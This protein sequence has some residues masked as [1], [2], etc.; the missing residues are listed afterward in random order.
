[1]KSWT[2]AVA[3]LALTACGD[4]PPPLFELQSPRQTGIAF[5]N[6]IVEDDS[7][8]NPQNFD[9]VYNGGGVAVG[10]VNGD[11]RPDL[12]FT[13]NMVSS[14]LY[15]NTGELTFDD[16]TTTAG[17]GTD[18]W[19]T[20]VSMVDID[21]NGLLDIYVSVAGM[22]EDAR[23]NLLF[24][25]QGVGSDGVPRF[26]EEAKARGLADTGYSTL[27]AFFDY[28]RDGDLDLYLL[29]N[30]QEDFGRN[31]LRARL[32][33]GESAS[34]DRLYRN[35][36]DG[37]FTDVSAEAGITI[38][39]YGLGVT[40]SDLDQD[41]W[42]DVYVANDFLSNDLI[43][44]NNGDGTFTNRAATWLEHQAHNGMGMDVADYNNDARPDI[45]VLDMLP[46]G[47]ERQK[48][49]VGE[50][51]YDP[52]MMSLAMGY[53]PQYIRNMLQLNLGPGPDGELHFSE[54]GQLAGI[55]ATDWSWAPLLA[56]LDNDGL[57]DLFITNGYRRDVTN[58]D[59][60]AY[61][62]KSVRTMREAPGERR[63]RLFN[64]LKQ[65]PPVELRDYLF[66]N[67]GDL[68]FTDRSREWGMRDA[69]FANGA[70]YADLD[71]DGDLDLVVNNLDGVADVYRNR[72]DELA[73]RHYLRVVL[74]G[75]DGN[76]NGLGT[77]V[78]ARHQ[79]RTQYL[80]Q[81]PYRGY[82]STVDGVLHFGLGS[83]TVVDSLEIHWP[84]GRYQ[85]L[86]DVRADQR[87]TVDHRDAGPPPE[88]A[89]AALEPLLTAAPA[90][91]GL[92]Y[93]HTE[94]HAPEFRVTPLLPRKHSRDGPGLAI[95]DADGN[96][97]DDV[98]VGADRN[99]AGRI[100]FQ[101][102]PG[103]F[104]ETALPDGS[105]Y[106]DTGALFFDADGDGH[107]DLYVVSGGSFPPMKDA[108]YQDR[109]YVNDGR[110]GLSHAPDALPV[111]DAS[112]S[113]VVAA[114]YDGDG[115]LDLFVGGRI[116]PAE[117]PLPA[118]SFLLRN[119]SRPGSPKFTDVTQDVAPGLARTG[120]VTSALWTDFDLDG[121]VDL[122]VAG[123]WMPLTF[124]R[125]DGDAFTD[126]T[127]TTG[128]AESHGWWNSLAAGD[129]DGDGDTDYV[130]G[131]LGLNSR[132]RASP[133]EPVRV[134]AR[135][136]DGNG[137]I[138]PVLSY[139][140]QGESYPVAPR[141]LM[142]DQIRAMEARFPDYAGYAEA[143]L[144]RTFRR[145]EVADAY[146]AKSQVMESAWV[147]NLGNGE[148]AL[149]P[150]PVRAQFAP[151]FGMVVGDRNDDGALDILMVGNSYATETLFGWYDASVGLLLLGDGEGGFAEV[152]HAASG[153]FVDGDAKA[154]G[155]LRVD[156]D[157]SLILVTQND[158]SLAIFESRHRERRLVPVEP[159][160]AYAMITLADSTIRRQEFYYGSTFQS[161]SSRFLAVPPDAIRAAIFDFS[162][163][164][165]TLH[166]PPRHR[167]PEEAAPC[168]P[169]ASC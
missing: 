34:T 86:R 23:A 40:V 73:D 78:I 91:N 139:Y 143:T 33:K 93:A 90:D 76:R 8:V 74:R 42:P 151:V 169:H 68:T 24:V 138:D 157:R 22:D 30:G 4:A 69:G 95:G 120:L 155:E 39:G 132:F 168:E 85:L 71:A 153:F 126:V 167:R 31:M 159:L 107:L 20:G 25:N 82:K 101:H 131:N 152:D 105:A 144:E 29:T 18:V 163:S 83:A 109:L 92:R 55:H 2:P 1:M 50:S 129:F 104:E 158:D 36:G 77:R 112:G 54:I 37:T 57:K 12:Y 149:R 61:S 156:D 130:A 26:T 56:D 121:R 3:L 98:F 137:T 45:I 75:P 32:K 70:A 62:E 117:Y 48:M 125:N 11:G 140:L 47:N 160:D 6:E 154:A 128:L 59:Y 99:R 13:G 94:Q 14:R 5:A 118:Q 150:L 52:F 72:T 87:I 9:Y 113:S 49:M 161:Q 123:E 43:W 116:I 27:A 134:H 122:L 135:D 142:I 17:V 15:L 162:G 110:G 102:A 133:D 60:I 103:R 124:Y 53:E 51:N 28:D 145:E 7:V 38:E 111:E 79:G 67:N 166:F 66:Q 96:G 114:D 80:E 58:L 88:P 16:V 119:D 148:F 81:F 63:R 147:E 165:R 65:V 84:D 19:A 108:S 106:E 10:D 97:L 89:S 146:V 35:D 21:Q 115:D 127:P 136:F 141:D 41:G 100:F 164:S 46:P 44:V 64:Q